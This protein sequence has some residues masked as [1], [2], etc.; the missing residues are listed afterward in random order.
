MPRARA[1]EALLLW[2]ALMGCSVAEFENI[3]KL[4]Q[5]GFKVC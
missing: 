1:R 2:A 4:T 3:E 5:L